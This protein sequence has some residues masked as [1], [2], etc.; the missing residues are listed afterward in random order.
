MTSGLEEAW[1]AAASGLVG[2]VI[3]A[4]STLLGSIISRKTARDSTD[5]TI[6]ANSADIRA[7]ISANSAN[8]R[9]QIEASAATVTAQI[10]AERRSRIWERQA[11]AYTDAIQGIRH[12]QNIRASQVLNIITGSEPLAAPSS[13][14]WNEVE[15]RLIAY[16]SPGVMEK[17]RAASDA[18]REFSSTWRMLDQMPP[19]VQRGVA[20]EQAR[21]EARAADTL[22]DELMDT[23]RDELHAS[24]ARAPEPP[25][26]LAASAR[27]DPR[28]EGDRAG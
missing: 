11:A 13:I 16:A 23:I 14:D 22:D 15:A 28:P 8:I 17:L 9:A 10:E 27:K 18:G 1:V 20:A 5:S 3:G 4:V 12:Q 26:P 21:Q 7:Q 2:V 6:A 25:I 24:S 19:G